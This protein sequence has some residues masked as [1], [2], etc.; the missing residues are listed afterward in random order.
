MLNPMTFLQF[1]MTVIQSLCIE[2]NITRY[3]RSF[4]RD[5]FFRPFVMTWCCIFYAESNGFFF[6]FL[7]LL[8][9]VCLLIKTSNAS[10]VRNRFIFSL[11]MKQFCTFVLLNILY[12]YLRPSF[13]I[14]I[15]YTIKVKSVRYKRNIP[16]YMIH[17]ICLRFKVKK[18]QT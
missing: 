7:K 11:V 3:C 6:N 16:R 17:R 4:V 18:C 8:L 15:F 2:N 1:S 5:Q 9:K 10:F 14:R 12:N 13:G